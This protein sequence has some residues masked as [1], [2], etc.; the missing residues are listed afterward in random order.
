M[1]TIGKI[2]AIV[3][4]CRFGVLSVE[5]ALSMIRALL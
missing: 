1:E 5:E 2:Y 3:M 4:Q